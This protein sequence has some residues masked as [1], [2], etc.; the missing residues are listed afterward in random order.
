MLSQVYLL[1][2]WHSLVSDSSLV[3]INP[4]VVTLTIQL[5]LL[6]TTSYS[7]HILSSG[8][9]TKGIS[10]GNSLQ[11]LVGWHDLSPP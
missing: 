8:P 10:F 3:Y 11:C 9:C 5:V 7:L 4:V 2:A 1:Y 6:P